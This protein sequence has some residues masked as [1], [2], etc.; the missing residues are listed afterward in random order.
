[1]LSAPMSCTSFDV[2]VMRTLPNVGMTTRHLAARACEHL[3]LAGVLKSA[4]KDHV[5]ACAT[6]R[7]EKYTADFFQ[8]L[9]RCH[10]DYETKIQEALLIKK[11]N[12]TLNKQLY[13]KGASFLLSTFCQIFCYDIISKS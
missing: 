12:P 2:R 7:D 5:R 8:I 1:M 9:K 6:C 11:L 3:V 10:T 4:I 13:A